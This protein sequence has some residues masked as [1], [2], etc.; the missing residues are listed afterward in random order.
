MAPRALSQDLTA[1]PGMQTIRGGFSPEL[2]VARDFFFNTTT[3]E[4]FE[5]VRTLTMDVCEMLDDC[6]IGTGVNPAQKLLG[7]TRTSTLLS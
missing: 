1:N 7:F 2:S 5:H 4:R 6:D 3:C